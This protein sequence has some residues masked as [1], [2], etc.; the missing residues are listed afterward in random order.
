MEAERSAEI[1]QVSRNFL[2]RRLQPIIARGAALCLMLLTVVAVLA[3][4]VRSHWLPYQQGANLPA[5]PLPGET[6]QALIAGERYLED[7]TKYWLI[8]N[9]PDEHG[10]DRLYTHNI[11]IDGPIQYLIRLT[12]VKSH[13]PLAIINAC[14]FVAGIWLGYLTVLRA[15][16]D[17]RVALA[18]LFFFV[19]SYYF[20]LLFA[21]NMRAWQWLGLFGVLLSTL[22]MC[23]SDH[24]KRRGQLWIF[25]AALVALACAYD[26]AAEVGMAALAVTAVNRKGRAAVFVCAAFAVA[27]ALRQLQVIGAIG[28]AAWATDVWYSALIKTA[29]LTRLTGMPD[30]GA[31]QSWYEAH[32]IV[33]F[34]AFPSSDGLRQYAHLFWDLFKTHWLPYMG[35]SAI[36]LAGYLCVGARG[37]KFLIAI[38]VGMAAGMLFFAPYAIHFAVKHAVP[39]ILAPVAL[40]AAVLVATLLSRG[41][42]GLAAALAIVITHLIVQYDVW[43]DFPLARDP[44]PRL[45]NFFDQPIKEYTPLTL[46]PS[47][48]RSQAH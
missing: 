13:V 9:L 23:G 42:V 12:G 48:Q 28:L 26:F 27:L 15:S 17:E 46:E 40:A 14:A 39:L 43:R 11:N 7:G 44:F 2:D 31:I 21:F 38:T 5:H 6:F 18:F 3:L 29:I 47:G 35:A 24:E 20:N 37:W 16:G 30:L 4:G 25:P 8:E 1:V 45:A 34:P 36:G 10:N 19:T 41:W 32:H 33:R 22:L